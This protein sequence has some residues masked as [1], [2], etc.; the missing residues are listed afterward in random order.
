[1]ARLEAINGRLWLS[2]FEQFEALEKRRAKS[3]PSEM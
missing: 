2:M 3:E 1:M